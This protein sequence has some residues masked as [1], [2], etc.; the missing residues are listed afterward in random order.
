MPSS[1]GQLLV[2]FFQ[3]KLRPAMCLRLPIVS[4]IFLAHSPV[5]EPLLLQQ[6]HLRVHNVYDLVYKA[7]LLRLVGANLLALKN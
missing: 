3:K 2:D 5:R 4:R 6:R 1:L 7:Y